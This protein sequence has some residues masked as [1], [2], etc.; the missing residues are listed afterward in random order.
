MRTSLA[1]RL[2]DAAVISDGGAVHFAT[3][4]DVQIFAD[5]V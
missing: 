5:S 1:A 3:I 4:R 2:G